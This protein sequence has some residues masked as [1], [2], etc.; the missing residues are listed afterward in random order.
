[1]TDITITSDPNQEVIFHPVDS[2]PKAISERQKVAEHVSQH[3]R[4]Y[5]F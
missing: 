2:E 5:L 1:M 3:Y 4:K